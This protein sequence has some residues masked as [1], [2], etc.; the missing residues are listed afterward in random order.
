MRTLTRVCRTMV[1]LAAMLGAPAPALADETDNFTCRAR[2][3]R[4]S[5]RA[6]DA[7][8]NARIQA[9]IA[10]ANRRGEAGCDAKCLY[11]E[12]QNHVAA[13]SL[14]PLTLVP[15]ARFEKWITQLP[16]LD[17]CHLDFSDTIYGA[18]PYDQ[19]WLFPFHGRIIF[20][21]DSILLSGRVVGLDKI[22][23]F[24]REGL[25]HWR[26]VSLRGRDIASVLGEELGSPRR[27]FRPTEY[28]LKGWSLTGVLAYADLAAGYSGFRFWTDLLSIEG[29]AS[30]VARDASTGQFVQARQ[31][32]FAAY[33]NDAWDEG[34]NYSVFGSGLDREVASAL[35]QR[36]FSLP[37]CDCRALASLP[38]A[39][40]YV[41]PA[42]LVPR[43]HFPVLSASSSLNQFKIRRISG[44][45]APSR[46]GRSIRNRSPFG[47]TAYVC[48]LSV[49]GGV[50]PLKSSRALPALKTAPG[51]MG[52]AMSEVPLE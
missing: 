41:N 10:R 35:A 23:H 22:N 19:P 29:P 48:P 47:A 39:R 36:G 17:R 24:I 1:V 40:L 37:V 16:G 30:Y 18:R 42:C 7:L 49:L 52:T 33:A 20:V 25:E 5:L 9:A 2:L 15:H 4:D 38:D 21:A 13:R 34:I 12:L 50:R 27:P 3:T 14:D 8:M 51:W 6:L 32:T 26:D 11:V 44:G 31:F 46:S 45:P 28:G 43:N